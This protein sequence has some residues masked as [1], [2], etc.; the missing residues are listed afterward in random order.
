[1]KLHG[2]YTDNAV[3]QQNKPFVV[4]GFGANGK[5]T[6]QICGECAEYSAYPDSEGRFAIQVPAHPGGFGKHEFIV[7]DDSECIRIHNIRF[8]DVYL[9]CGQSNMQLGVGGVENAAE[10]MEDCKRHAEQ[11]FVLDIGERFFDGEGNIMR[12]SR[13]LE[14]IH[15]KFV[16][17]AAS[18]PAIYHS[19]AVGVMAAL[20]LSSAAG[21][22]IG[23]VNTALG[24]VQICTYLAKTWIDGDA[25]VKGYLRQKG[26]YLEEAQY[27]RAQKENY[28]QMSGVYNEKIAPLKGLSFRAMFW[29][30]GESE[31]GDYAASEYYLRAF[32]LLMR[33]YRELFGDDM[34][35][36]A[37]QIAHEVYPYAPD[38]Y[39][40]VNEAIDLAVQAENDRVGR[41]TAFTVPTYDI[42]PRWYR[43]DAIDGDHPIHPVNKEKIAE[44]IAEGIE[45]LLRGKQGFSFPKIRG[46]KYENGYAVIAVDSEKPLKRGEV[47]G[48]TIKDAFGYCPVRAQAV[49]D[50]TVKIF[51]ERSQDPVEIT[52]AFCRYN[53]YCDL[54]TADGTPVLPYRRRRED[55]GGRH[56]YQ[57]AGYEFCKTQ[58]LHEN[59]Y[60]CDCGAFVPKPVW[61]QGRITDAHVDVRLSEN[62]VEARFY[63]SLREYFY[64]GISPLVRFCGSEMVWNEFDGL[65]IALAPN[66]SGIKFYGILLRS[67]GWVYRVPAGED[68]ADLE[69]EQDAVFRLPFCKM[70]RGNG[71][72]VKQGEIAD[73]L[74]HVAEAE[75]YFRSR[76][77]GVV[78]IRSL[79]PYRA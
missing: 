72:T 29:Y 5:V 19:S 11:I 60:G 46:V 1:M 62:G 69:R 9:T 78:Y 33:Q 73:I 53:M 45:R 37:V 20:R 65:E 34:W 75:V 35:I 17:R 41:A 58:L 36:A 54:K 42:I 79:L 23:L 56:Y 18:D 28:T 32:G 2:I 27:N 52:Y 70:K 49:G 7:C 43:T 51:A 57:L 40:Y 21:V 31:A 12:S 67:D 55:M 66:K 74:R 6:F 16:W 8:G 64:F 30:L 25:F 71:E 13:P 77:P 4:K 61:A 39:M 22:P 47:Q 10:V 44:R 26:A 38:G 14:D 68:S 24:G 63:P 15:Q 59:N 50:D 76:E 3:I 48:F